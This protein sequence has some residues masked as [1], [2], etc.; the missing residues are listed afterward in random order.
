MIQQEDDYSNTDQETNLNLLRNQINSDNVGAINIK[1]LSKHFGE[2][3]A[4]DD[5]SMDINSDEVF[6][7][8]G[9]NG[10]GKTTLINILTGILS[11]TRGDA[12]VYGN[13]LR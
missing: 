5:V 11:P 12:R 9:H 2:F 8:L 13:W 4:V 10:A 3:K 1:N 7:L 6:C